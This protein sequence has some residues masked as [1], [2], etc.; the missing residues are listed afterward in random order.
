[1]GESTMY[2]FTYKELAE[3]LV[4]KQ[5]IHDGLWGVYVKFTL[6]AANI[7]D[8]NG[9]LIPAAISGIQEIG[10]QRFDQANNLTVDAAQVNPLPVR[11]TAGKTLGKRIVGKK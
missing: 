3:V 2:V 11:R 4:K 1:M 10:I 7:P 9:M 6:G 5:D 8:P